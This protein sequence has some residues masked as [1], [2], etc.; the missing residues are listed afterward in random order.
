MAET[1]SN[2]GLKFKEPEYPW[3]SD[4]ESTIIANFTIGSLRDSVMNWL[5]SER[6][7][8]A[9]LLLVAI[10]AIAGFA[11]QAAAFQSIGPPGTPIPDRKIVMVEAGGQ[12]YYF[13]DRINGYLVRQMNEYAYPLWGFVAAAAM[14]C[15]LAE[16]DLP[17]V[18]EMF[19]HTA[20]S[21]GKPEFGVPRVPEGVVPAFTPH[22]ALELF[23]PAAKELLSNKDDLLLP[24]SLKSTPMHGMSVPVAHWPL[25]VA[26][27]ARQFIFS[28]KDVL[29]PDVAF[30][31]IME[32]A[33]A[34][35]KVDPTTVR[36]EVPA[37][38]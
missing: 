4:T 12:K 9:E 34:M 22:K 16:K 5:T 2:D 10:G 19:A 35:S 38:R 21:I 26:L 3:E 30:R 23:W 13:G 20:K 25:I 18:E 11:A 37:T 17:D 1:T 15:G 28:A 29:K 33:I 6:G 8:H 36:Q 24:S 14:Q 7:V 31:L 32:S 27:V